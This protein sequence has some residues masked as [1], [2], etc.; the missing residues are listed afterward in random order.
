[1]KHTSSSMPSGSRK[2]SDHVSPSWSDLAD[3]GAEIGK[4]VARLLERCERVDRQRV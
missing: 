1:M 3:V 4:T 2:N